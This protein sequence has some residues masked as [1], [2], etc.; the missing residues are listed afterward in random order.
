MATIAGSGIGTREHHLIITGLKNAHGMEKQA[1][2][3]K[4][5]QMQRI[6]H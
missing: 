6:Q 4:T 1:L 5:P 3:V 2:S